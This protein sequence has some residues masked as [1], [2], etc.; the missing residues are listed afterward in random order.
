MFRFP[1]PHARPR[2]A[3]WRWDTPCR[4]RRRPESRPARPASPRAPLDAP[5]P[6]LPSCPS[7]VLRHVCRGEERDV[8]GVTLASLIEPR[9]LAA[10]GLRGVTNG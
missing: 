2:P 4:G 5:V 10:L 9:Y 1:A 3:L 8:G 6:A 7:R